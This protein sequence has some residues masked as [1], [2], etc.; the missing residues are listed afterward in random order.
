LN[1]E[2][3]GERMV[4]SSSDASAARAKVQRASQVES[5]GSQEYEQARFRAGNVQAQGRAIIDDPSGTA[6][7][8][9]QGRAE[10]AGNA[11]LDQELGV[12]L[13][14]AASGG[15]GIKLGATGADIGSP[16][17][18]EREVQVQTSSAAF[19]ADIEAGNR[20]EAAHDV[21]DTS[22]TAPD[23]KGGVKPPRK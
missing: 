10:N 13:G 5:Q 23:T 9:A 7:G 2:N 22:Q 21:S 12:G 19:G 8:F 4:D 20:T 18:L 3:V 11:A 14:A 1:A 17:Q 6:Q 16:D 15:T